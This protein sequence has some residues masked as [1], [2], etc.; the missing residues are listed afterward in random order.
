MKISRTGLFTLI[1]LL[2]V[3]AIIAILAAMLLP[4]LSAAR[5]RARTSNCIANLKQVGISMQMYV[6]DNDN[7][8]CNAGGDAG[9]AQPYTWGRHLSENCSY[10]QD[11]KILYCPSLNNASGNTN[12]EYTYGFRLKNDSRLYLCFGASSFSWRVASLAVSGSFTSDPST[13]MMIGDTVRTGNGKFN[14]QFYRM[15]STGYQG[16]VDCRHSKTANMLYADGHAQNINGE[17]LGDELEARGT[18]SY[19]LGTEQRTQSA[20]N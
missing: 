19:Y 2:V 20:A 6:D 14:D 7:W 11:T 12:L 10:I 18:W 9:T 4:A 17:E 3:I 5:E 1:E 16:G 8:T 13:F 15:S